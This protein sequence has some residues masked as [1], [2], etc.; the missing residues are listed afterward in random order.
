M[1]DDA[2]FAGY[3]KLGIPREDSQNY[4]LLG[5]YEP[6]IMGLEEG[7]IGICWLNMTKS[8]EFAINGGKDI[9]TDRQTGVET[10]KDIASFNEFFEVFLNQLDNCIDFAIDFAQ[11]Q[12]EYSTLINPSPIYSSTFAECIEKGM[13]VHE[14]PLKY[15]NMGLKLFGTATVI[16]SL[17]AIKKY[18]F[19]RKEITFEEL[20]SALKK[21][22]SGYEEIQQILSKDKDKYGNNREL[23][24]EIL[25]K[26]TKHLED[27]YCGK[28]LDR[29]GRLRLGLD[30]IDIC[31]YMGKTTSATPD[32][33]KSGTP[34]SKNLC[35]SS[36]KDLGGI[37]AYMQTVL[38]IDS[39]A[40][41]NGAPCDFILHP[42]SVEGEKGLADFISLIEIFF[43]NGGFALQ[44]N[45]FNKETLIKARENPEKYSTLQIRVCGWNE[46]FV[47]L[48][49]VT[50]DM[51]IKQCEVSR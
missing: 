15:N 17:S 19:D 7:E 22:W 5:C 25:V 35:A 43:A 47:K 31:T 13:D 23:P 4:V 37:T 12:G 48:N 27:K 28:R 42:S 36:G 44:G 46:Y 1:N 50:Q 32:G 21:D 3:E 33:R 2:V 10:P 29:G 49:K 38:K 14:Y 41:V 24:D 30:S 51:F 6:I 11:K 8:I 18:V 40:F 45:V 26:L 20:R 34:V 16:D 39:S 9:I